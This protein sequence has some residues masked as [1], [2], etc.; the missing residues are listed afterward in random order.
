[1]SYSIPQ[2]AMAFDVSHDQLPI[3]LTQ[4]INGVELNF[5]FDY[6]IE[7]D[8]YTVQISDAQDNLLQCAKLTYGKDV[9]E[10][11]A[12]R[13]GLKAKIIP[14]DVGRELS[15]IRTGNPRVGIDNF[16]KSVKLVVIDAG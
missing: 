14:L 1:M 8:F 5:S 4:E 11:V 10:R 13:L 7:G 12:T 9:F 15:D 6:N 16:G 3:I 2:D